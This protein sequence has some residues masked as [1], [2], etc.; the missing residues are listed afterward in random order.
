MILRVD[1]ASPDATNWR[2]ELECVSNAMTAEYRRHIRMTSQE[3]N[4]ELCVEAPTQDKLVI[5]CGYLGQRVARRWQQ[6]G[7]RVFVTTRSQTRADAFASDGFLPLQMDVTRPD[8]WPVLPRVT[9]VCYCVGYD[10]R[11]AESRQAV[12]VDGL[13]NVLD[14]LPEVSDRIIYVSSTGVYAQADDVW[15]DEQSPCDPRREGGVVCRA[16][17]DVLRQHPWGRRSVILRMAGLYGP[18]RIP[19]LDKI[20]R[21]EPLPVA[22]EGYLNLVHVDDAASV[23]LAAAATSRLPDLFVVADG[24]PVRRAEYYGEIARQLGK[25]VAFAA[26]DPDSPQAAR[27]A[28][29]KRICVEKLRRRLSI[30]WQYPSYREGLAA[31]LATE[32]GAEA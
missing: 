30:P 3:I 14:A 27:A 26:A 12:Y 23:V 32:R 29:S 22:A 17:E 31:C 24:S 25:Q 7:A 15:V 2:I 20:R 1:V 4:R 9:Q 21:G 19:Y 13:R 8:T 5:G 16:A 18:G 10:S 28:S 11:A 6:A